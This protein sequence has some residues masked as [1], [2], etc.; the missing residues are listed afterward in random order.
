MAVWVNRL[1]EQYP[2]TI[3]Q[4]QTGRKRNTRRGCSSRPNHTRWLTKFAE[5]ADECQWT[6]ALEW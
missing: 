3:Q 6:S 2:Y 5:S 4:T 1:F